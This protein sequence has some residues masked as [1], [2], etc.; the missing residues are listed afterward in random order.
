MSEKYNSYLLD[1]NGNK[2]IDL[3]NGDL[4]VSV[5]TILKGEG[6]D[7][8]TWALRQFG[9]EENPLKAYQAYM[10]KVSDLGSRIHAYV[11]HDLKDIPL[12]ANQ[13]QEDMLPAIKAWHNFKN[14]NK[15]EMIASERIVFSPKWRI[16][17]TCDLVV[18]INDVLYV[19]DFKTG[20]IYPSAFTQMAAYKAFMCQEP[21]SKRIEGIENADLAV[22][23]LHR[24][25]GPV[26]FSTLKLYHKGRVSIEDELG[27]FH[28][29]RYLWF[30]RNVKSRK[31]EAVI[32]NMREVFHPLEERFK[33][34]FKL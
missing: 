18:K 19:A 20:G 1:K 9:P 30:Q 23:G 33:E 17:G 4:Y 10:E 22:I 31:F 13:V 26:D 34:A 15:I 6:K 24:D 14:A 11:E 8:I 21:K 3:E 25:G 27:V 29:L 5:S 12:D 7:L 28:C 32:K 2:T 16:A